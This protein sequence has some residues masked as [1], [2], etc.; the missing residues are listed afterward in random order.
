MHATR[1][2]SSSSVSHVPQ[3]TI[4]ADG[5]CAVWGQWRL[6]DDC[7][8]YAADDDDA[9]AADD[10]DIGERCVKRQCLSQW[11]VWR[12]PCKEPSCIVI[13][14]RDDDDK[15]EDRDMRMMMTMRITR[16]MM[17]M[18]RMMMIMMR[19]MMRIMMM[20][21]LWC[22]ISDDDDYD[23][24]VRVVIIVITILTITLPIPLLPSSHPI[25]WLAAI[26]PPFTLH[27][28][29]PPMLQ[30]IP[31]TNPPSPPPA[32]H[33]PKLQPIPKPK[34]PYPTLQLAPPHCPHSVYP[35]LPTVPVPDQIVFPNRKILASLKIFSPY[36][37]VSDLRHIP[38]AHFFHQ[39][40][41]FA[42]CLNLLTLFS[43]CISMQAE[44]STNTINIWLLLR[45]SV[46]GQQR[47]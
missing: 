25:S 13:F 17:I 22:L 47:T 45:K 9:D 42:Q 10:Q 28:P 6:N 20:M 4:W 26:S 3:V 24:C 36:G 29:S 16:L 34:P 46:Y 2:L 12:S 27:P 18:M 38:K 44:P 19:M 37:Y 15:E 23:M 21:M 35:L 33:I 14:T 5:I 41:N 32:P 31:T 11:G 7:F 1:A 43:P 30:P 39:N 40:V 8:V